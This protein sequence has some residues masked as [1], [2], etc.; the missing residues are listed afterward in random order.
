MLRIAL[1][2]LAAVAAIILWNAGAAVVGA[3]PLFLLCMV[4]S[5]G[6]GHARKVCELLLQYV[7]RGDRSSQLWELQEQDAQN[8][9]NAVCALSGASLQKTRRDYTIAL[10]AQHGLYWYFGGSAKVLCRLTAKDSAKPP[11][12]ATLNIRYKSQMAVHPFRICEIK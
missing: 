11:L 7:D 10:T 9:L 8:V 5:V 3:V 1:I 12:Q 6:K 2:L 4:V